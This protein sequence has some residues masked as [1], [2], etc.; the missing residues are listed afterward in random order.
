MKRSVIKKFGT[1]KVKFVLVCCLHGDEPFGRK[2]FRYFEKNAAKF[3]SFKLILA[4][5]EALSQKQRY[6]VSDLNRSF[7][8]RKNGNVEEKIAYRMMREIP[9][10]AYLIDLHTT[11]TEIQ[12]APIITTLNNYT[13][14]L[15][16]LCPSDHIIHVHKSL[17]RSSLIGQFEKG[18]SV[19]INRNYAK[20]DEALERVVQLV[21]GLI[22]GKRRKKR[23]RKVFQVDGV[24]A[25]SIKLPKK[26]TNFEKIR[27]LGVYPVLYHKHSYPEIHA[28][29]AKSFVSMMI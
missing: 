13:K 28:M 20:T 10:S 26:V 14:K 23:E 4:H 16:N 22:Q 9:E 5:P 15:L 27:G 29:S 21:E 11:I 8:G 25:K 19:E 17:N 1:G 6:I 12:F 18:L 7:P 3:G 2:A 24:I